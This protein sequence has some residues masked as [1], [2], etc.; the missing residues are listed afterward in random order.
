MLN[1][2]QFVYFGD[3]RPLNNTSFYDRAAESY[4]QMGYVPVGCVTASVRH[5]AAVSVSF[6][7]H[8]GF[9]SVSE[10]TYLIDF[11]DYC[12]ASGDFYALTKA[13]IVSS[14]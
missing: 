1:P 14:E 9:Q 7:R 12:V 11:D 10:G 6:C 4:S 8:Y 2:K 5:D 13:V 3:S